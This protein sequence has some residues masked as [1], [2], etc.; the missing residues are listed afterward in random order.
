MIARVWAARA[1][2]DHAPAY[3]EHLRDHVLP[4]LRGLD[5]Y[6]GAKLL[7]RSDGD[8]VEIVVVTYWRSLDAVRGFAGDAIDAAVVA[9]EAAA[10][11][12]DFDARVQHFEVVATDEP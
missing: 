2:P 12:T 10:L 5:G 9:D 1:T 8:D 4:T 6:R 7:Q 11:L 3:A